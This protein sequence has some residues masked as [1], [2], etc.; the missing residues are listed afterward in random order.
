[1]TLNMHNNMENTDNK[2]KFIYSR[3]G[4]TNHQKNLK[5]NNNKSTT[6][7]VAAPV[8]YFFEW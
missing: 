6:T 8:A 4:N 3:K 1:M 5:H 2:K 7:T